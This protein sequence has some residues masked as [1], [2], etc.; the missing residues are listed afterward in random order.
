MPKTKILIVE[1]SKLVS[2]LLRESLK[3]LGYAVA[4]VV[5]SGEEA[6][7][8]AGEKKPDLVLMDIV[9][10]GKLDGIDTANQIHSKFKIPV[11]YLTSFAEEKTLERARITEPFGYMLKPFKERELHATIEMALYKKKMEDALLKAHLELEK[12]V[13]M[14][15]SE[16]KT[17]Y[18]R[19][20]LAHE[21]LKALDVLK[22]NIIANVSH[23]LR[24]P[25]TIAHTAIELAMLEENEKERKKLLTM[26]MRA[27]RRQ[28][29]IVEDLVEAARP[30][31]IN[32]GESPKELDLATL[33]ISI[34]S[35]FESQIRKN[36]E[37]ITI[38]VLVD[39]NLPKVF[40][41]HNQMLH[42]VRNLLHNAIKFNKRGGEVIIEACKRNGM[43][44]ISVSDTGI[45]I[46]PDQQKKIFERFY[47]IDSSPRRFYGGTGMGLAIAKEIVESHGG[48]L[49]VESEVDR[50]SKFTI[51]LP[52][53]K[54]AFNG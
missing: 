11:V 23:E 46:Q 44:E 27:F 1:D 20:N 43:V 10:E 16:L 7:K 30:E 18:E 9:L 38:A 32:R 45:G 29:N 48:E 39:E 24:T 33:L 13:E 6:I 5:E 52:A 21:E 14:R 2:K 37:N 31:K 8:S 3:N 36:N 42:V 15:T 34:S 53:A 4:G 40:A 41:D 50:G 17:A 25:I 35:E 28:N 19:L 47:Q 54:G 22:D 51:S 26:A 49:T 12:K